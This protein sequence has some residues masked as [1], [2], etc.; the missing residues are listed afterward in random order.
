MRLFLAFI[1]SLSL[2][3]MLSA[4][5]EK[6][7][8]AKEITMSGTFKWN[9]RGGNQPLKAVFTQ[10]DKDTWSVVFTF[11]W[12]KKDRIY[13]GTATGNLKTDKLSGQATDETKKRTWTFKGEFDKDGIFKGTHAE[14][15]RGRAGDTGVF[16]LKHAEE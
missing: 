1:L 5:E 10:K 14:T 4:Q 3:V 12:G 8:A 9:K 16:Q 6:K 13:T 11:K 2:P 7:P 15:T